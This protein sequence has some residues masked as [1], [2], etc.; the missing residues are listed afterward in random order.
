MLKEFRKAKKDQKSSATTPRVWVDVKYDPEKEDG[1]HTTSAI[2]KKIARGAA[3]TG[4]DAAGTWM[5]LPNW[6]T[7]KEKFPPPE[8]APVRSKSLDRDEKSQTKKDE[9]GKG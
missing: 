5:K 9:K 3:V 8:A 7:L 2:Q 1:K 6:N 4:E